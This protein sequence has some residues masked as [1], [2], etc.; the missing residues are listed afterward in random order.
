MNIQLHLGVL[1]DP[2]LQQI[3][4]QGLS[5]NTEKA[6]HAQSHLDQIN[7]LFLEDLLTEKEAENAKRKL[8][9]RIKN[10]VKLN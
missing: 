6:K 1:A 5:L 7:S 3:E 2:I 10:H 9:N 4:M 8:F